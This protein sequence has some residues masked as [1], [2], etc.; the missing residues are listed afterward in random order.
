M[1]ARSWPY[2][3]DKLHGHATGMCLIDLSKSKA[4]DRVLRL[5]H[6]LCPAREAPLF[7]HMLQGERVCL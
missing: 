2:L 3:R 6:L 4:D 1:V 5:A 7:M